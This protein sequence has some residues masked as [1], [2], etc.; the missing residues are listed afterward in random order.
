MTV[1]SQP[2]SQPG[3][4]GSLQ[5]LSQHGMGVSSQP[6]GIAKRASPSVK[7]PEGICCVLQL[8]AGLPPLVVRHLRIERVQQPIPGTHTRAHE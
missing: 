3:M 4:N 6:L 2:L 8:L 5:P 7:H 1:A